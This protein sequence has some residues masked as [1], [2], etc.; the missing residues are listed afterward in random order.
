MEAIQGE[1]RGEQLDALVTPHVSGGWHL[2]ATVDNVVALCRNN[3][4]AY[5]A[6]QPLRN[7]VAR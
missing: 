5:L 4:K 2:Q 6:D 3:L 1:D 7:V